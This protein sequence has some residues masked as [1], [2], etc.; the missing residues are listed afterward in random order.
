MSTRKSMAEGLAAFANEQDLRQAKVRLGLA[1]PDEGWLA[2]YLRAVTPL[3]DAPAEFHLVSGLCALSAA[4]GNRLHTREWGQNVFPHLWAVLVA[5]SSF[6]RKSTAIGQAQALVEAGAPDAIYPEDFSREKLVALFGEK[7]SGLLVLKEFGGFLAMLGRDYMTGTKEM[8]TGLYDG[9]EVY[10][11]ALKKDEV[12]IQR[13]AITLLGATTLDWLEAKITEGDLQGGFL[14]RFLF[15]TAK[16]KASPK[17]LTGDIDPVLRTRLVSSL[18]TVY[19]RAP[20]QITYEPAAREA[21]DEWMLGWEAEVMKTPHRSDLS[22][23]AVR[24]QTYALKLAMLYRASATAYEDDAEYSLVDVVSVEQAIAYVRHLWASVAGLI[25]EK[26]AITKEARELRRVLGIV[27]SGAT[28]SQA[29]KLSKLKARDFDQV[30]DTLVQSGELYRA[31]VHASDVGLERDRDK[32]LEWLSPQPV[33]SRNGH[34]D[35]DLTV[36]SYGSPNASPEP[37][38]TVPFTS[39]GTVENSNEEGIV[40]LY[41]EPLAGQS[42]QETS[43]HFTSLSSLSPDESGRAPRTDSRAREGNSKRKTSSSSSR[44]STKRST[45]SGDDEVRL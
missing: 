45:S 21:Y 26:I 7:P 30:V 31:K 29:L 43:L 20:T 38:P 33:V 40:E 34:G 18:Q 28:R 41:G 1:L 5:P 23:F 25:D 10:K 44:G 32:P 22:G 4:I 11:R 8:L 6:W 15:V 2:D 3:T 17:G 9:P 14:A 24:L 42:E 16:E 13:P 36:P 12:I 27:G 39:P 35:E 37:E 19:Q